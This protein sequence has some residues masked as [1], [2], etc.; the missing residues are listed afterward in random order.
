M[1]IEIGF[2]ESKWSEEVATKSGECQDQNLLSVFVP[3][4]SVNTMCVTKYVYLVFSSMLYGK[5]AKG[6]R[7]T[8]STVRYDDVNIQKIE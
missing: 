6:L 4:S 2:C 5:S 1:F 7:Q 3:I 8:P